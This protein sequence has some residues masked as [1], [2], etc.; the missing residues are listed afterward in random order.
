[1]RAQA[2]PA[3][4][5]LYFKGGNGDNGR[6]VR[7]LTLSVPSVSSGKELGLLRSGVIPLYSS[8]RQP[9]QADGV[10][11]EETDHV[12]SQRIRYAAEIKLTLRKPLYIPAVTNG[13]DAYR[14]LQERLQAARQRDLKFN[15]FLPGQGPPV[16]ALPLLIQV[17]HHEGETIVARVPFEARRR[18]WR[19]R[20]LPPLVAL[21]SA[22]HPLIG[23]S[24]EHF[25]SAP[26]L[27]FGDPNSRAEIRVLMKQATD[28]MYSVAKEV[29]KRSEVQAMVETPKPA[30]APDAVAVPAESATA[31]ADAAAQRR[32][33]RPLFDPNAPAFDPNAPAVGAKLPVAD[34]NAP[35]VS[36]K[37]PAFDPNAPA[38]V[39]PSVAPGAPSP[40][41][42]K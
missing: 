24:L 9:L 22:N 11:F 12:D 4:R 6:T 18:G 3:R 17:S 23:D 28:Y 31:R 36:P 19:W 26:Y 2:R 37:A 21:R 8:A 39:V 33:G 38:I 1:M 25:A 41:A 32:G 29:Q 7:N 42:K 20:L 13:T 16:P 30:L 40:P 35:A 27:V 34:P 15:I 5:L 10:T 14:Q